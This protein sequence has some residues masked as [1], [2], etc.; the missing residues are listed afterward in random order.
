MTACP[1]EPSR[2]TRKHRR[3][4]TNP[5]H[6][7]PSL[8]SRLPGTARARIGT[9][10]AMAS[11]RLPHMPSAT[12]ELTNCQRAPCLSASSPH[13]LAGLSCRAQD[14]TTRN[15]HTELTPECLDGRCFSQRENSTQQDRDA[16]EAGREGADGGGEV[17]EAEELGVLDRREVRHA[18]ADERRAWPRH[19]ERVKETVCAHARGI[20]ECHA[21]ACAQQDPSASRCEQRSVTDRVLPAARSCLGVPCRCCASATLSAPARAPAPPCTRCIP[22]VANELSRCSLSF[23]VGKKR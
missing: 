5:S 17:E 4:E 21:L 9:R 7:H 14:P 1:A 23:A 20:T 18:F 3:R 22:R 2:L 11:R 13:L 19:R 15:L 16:Q 8:T 10:R 12:E 6:Y